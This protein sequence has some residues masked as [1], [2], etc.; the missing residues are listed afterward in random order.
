MNR[1]P[2]EMLPM[3]PPCEDPKCKGVLQDCIRWTEPRECYRRCSECGKEYGRMPLA[4]KMGWAVRTIKP[5]LS[6]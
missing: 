1:R 2:F 6:G 3:G 5:C 4:D